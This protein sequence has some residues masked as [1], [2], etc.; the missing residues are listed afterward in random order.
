MAVLGGFSQY[1]ERG[2]TK[3]NALLFQH[4]SADSHL[5]IVT[6]GA[7]QKPGES[8]LNLVERNVSIMQSIIPKVVKFSP[9]AVICIVTNPCDMMTAVA[10]KIAGPSFPPGRIFGSGTCLDSS[11]LQSLISKKLN[12]DTNSVSGYVIGE[13]GDTSVPVWSSVRVGGV[14]LLKNGEQPTKVHDDMHKE[15][16]KSAYDVIEK[17]GYTNWV[18]KKR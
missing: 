4:V 9:N 10:A 1:R 13:H 8:R 18:S 15:V 17:K 11:R 6:A 3:F 14:P 12:L 7:A 16:V 5:V 2:L